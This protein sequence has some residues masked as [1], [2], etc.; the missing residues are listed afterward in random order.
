MAF[1]QCHC[2]VRPVCLCFRGTERVTG[3]GRVAVSIQKLFVERFILPQFH[4]LYAAFNCGEQN[5]GNGK[6]AERHCVKQ[7]EIIVAVGNDGKQKS[8]CC[9]CVV[10][11][12]P[13]AETAQ[14]RTAQ[15]NDI[16]G[17]HA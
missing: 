14:P 17:E 15:M 6:V 9:L 8:R 13:D 2:A 1:R 11:Q 16:G 12:C 5:R 7:K 10:P 4:I 3:N